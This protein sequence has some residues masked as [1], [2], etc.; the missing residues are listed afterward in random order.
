[1]NKFHQYT[2]LVTAWHHVASFQ[3]S[4]PYKCLKPFLRRLQTT[5]LVSLFYV[6]LVEL[7]AVCVV[8]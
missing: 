3:T 1:M 7:V 8:H 4:K 2:T 5:P 6:P